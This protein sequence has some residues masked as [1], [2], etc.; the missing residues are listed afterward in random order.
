[1]LNEEDENNDEKLADNM[2]SDDE[3]SEILNLLLGSCVN[4]ADS[5]E[6]KWKLSTLFKPGLQLP[7]NFQ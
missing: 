7:N 4:P 6:A 1:M 3:S 2:E 5:D